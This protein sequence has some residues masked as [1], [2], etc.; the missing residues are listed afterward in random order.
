[1]YDNN[2]IILIKLQGYE[3]LREKNRGRN[4]N[5]ILAGR[6]YNLAVDEAKKAYYK[7]VFIL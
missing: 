4:S 2:F 1:M 7:L 5:A 6:N 3:T